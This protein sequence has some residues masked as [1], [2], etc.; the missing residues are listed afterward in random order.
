MVATRPI[1]LGDCGQGGEDGQR[2]EAVEP[3]LTLAS[4]RACGW[5]HSPQPWPTPWI[6]APEFDLSLAHASLL[7]KGRRRSTERPRLAS[8]DN[9]PPPGKGSVLE[10]TLC[11]RRADLLQLPQPTPG[12]RQVDEA[13]LRGDGAV[14]QVRQP[15]DGPVLEALDQFQVIDDPPVAC[16]QRLGKSKTT[17]RSSRTPR[18]QPALVHLQYNLACRCGEAQTAATDL[19][20]FLDQPDHRLETLV[21]E[22]IR[23]QA[24]G[25]VV[26]G[27]QEENVAGEQRLVQPGEQH[28][29]A[30]VVDV[31]L[32]EAQYPA[33]AEQVVE[34]HGQGIGPRG[35]ART[36]PGAGGRRNHGNAGGAWAGRRGPCRNRPAASSCPGRPGHAGTGCGPGRRQAR[37]LL[38]HGLDDLLLADAQGIA[39]LSGLVGEETLDA[40]VDSG[41]RRGAVIQALTQSAQG[42]ADPGGANRVPRRQDGDFET[43]RV[44]VG[45]DLSAIGREAA[46]NPESRVCLTHTVHSGFTT[47]LPSIADKSAPTPSASHQVGRQY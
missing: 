20:A 30:D 24:P 35:G 38:R 7:Q 45:A 25:R 13:L 12:P 42:R 10:Q 6:I 41:V 2:L 28:G 9:G 26:G 33:V 15:L 16:S 4:A 14:L 29:V 27:H 8:L 31:E 22:R 40:G 5:R 1:L 47:A 3:K 32:I 46:V 34:G 18:V 36:C 43:T 19:H 11:G 17:L 23:Q 37:R 21:I 39:L 44:G